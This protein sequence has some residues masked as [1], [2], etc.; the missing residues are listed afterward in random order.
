MKT[1][2]IQF[3]L[4]FLGAS[5]CYAQN[6]NPYLNPDLPIQQRVEDL[7]GRMTLKQKIGQ[8]NQDHQSGRNCTRA[9]G[10]IREGL[11]GSLIVTT[12][13]NDGHVINTLQRAAENTPLKIPLLMAIDAV[14]GHCY[15][16]GTTVFPTSI[17]MA[18][19]WNPKLVERSSLITAREMRATGY[20]WN[21]DPYISVSRD[22]RWGR[23][24]ENLGEDA[25][26]V[27]ELG[28]AK[29]RGYQGDNLS[30]PHSVLA[31]TKVLVGDGQTVNG[32]N[33]APM[34][35]SERTLREVFLPPFQACVDAGVWTVMAA[36]N[37][38]GGI[39]CHAS[40]FLLT[41]VLRSE[42]GFAGLVISDSRDIEE[43]VRLHR[44]AGNQ[45]EA[46]QQAVSAGVDVHMSGDGF[47][48][49]LVQLVTEGA[50]PIERIDR[51]VRKLLEA[52]FRLGL[53]ENRYLDEKAVDHTLASKEHRQV[54]LQL[55]R[56]SIVL[57]KNKGGILPLNK[58]TGS[59]FITGPNANNSSIL[60]DWV[61]SQPVKN[62]STVVGGI[63][64][65]VS[66][67]TK[68]DYYK[69]GNIASI[70]Q[71]DIHRAAERARKANVAI[72]VVGG[73]DTRYADFIE[74]GV[75]YD[76][77]RK[78]KL[79]PERTGGEN[80][81]RSCIDLAGRQLDLVRAVFETGTPTIVVL[82]NGRPLAINWIDKH[83]PAIIEAWQPGMEGGRAVA[84][85]VFGDYN[86]G[87]RLP[88]T[89]PRS[90]GH[91]QTW[92][93]QRQTHSHIKY[94]FSDSS[95]LYEFGHGLSYTTFEYSN[96]Q[97]P[98]RLL[99]GQGLRASVDVQN[100]GQFTGDEVVQVYAK[101]MVS[102]VTTP[103]KKLVAFERITLQPGQKRRVDLA[104]PS[105][106]LSLVNRKMTYAVE[107]GRF[108]LMVGS[109]KEGFEA[110]AP[111]SFPKNSSEGNEAR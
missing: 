103:I 88:I 82:V 21:F 67:D 23:V 72:L 18:S 32:R 8:M 75:K 3:L 92:Y 102:S 38:V 15:F 41:D 81:D 87:G 39:P 25:L 79:R 6:Q 2:A 45:K 89:F 74:G 101:D 99:I 31:C 40:K 24:G 7:I 84:E 109:L 64:D 53:F 58:K 77:R 106:R 17:G 33:F 69:C 10:V 35:V 43:L 42:M 57:L 29:V 91:L 60:G 26:L 68:V 54:A 14:H 52:K 46:V 108:E 44:V 5:I 20:Q 61:V 28:V 1:N 56:E 83:V 100:T 95:P 12:V 55:A 30:S 37:E 50:I 13:G 93:A 9:V 16:P 105:N 107:P 85:V 73:D 63:R 34:D 70:S 49:P 22:P 86:P 97:V 80:I 47:V 90:T 19:T 98:K 110:V 104:I 4:I 51:A 96:L 71:E 59:I 65:R 76:D 78:E 66:A 111:L 27:S 62:V 94:K 48:E 36:H 11:A